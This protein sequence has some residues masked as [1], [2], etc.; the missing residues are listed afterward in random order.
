VNG[1]GHLSMIIRSR[2]NRLDHLFM[3]RLRL[4]LLFSMI[5]CQS[6]VWILCCLRNLL[7]GGRRAASFKFQRPSTNMIVGRHF[8]E[9]KTKTK[10]KW[11]E[12]QVNVIQAEFTYRR[13]KIKTCTILG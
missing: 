3:V 6:S 5:Q 7:Y 8:R 4:F 10:K 1:L 12:K 9:G 11:G 2:F 13:L